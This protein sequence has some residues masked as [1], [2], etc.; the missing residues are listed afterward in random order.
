ML[1]TPFY[2]QTQTQ[3]PVYQHHHQQHHHQ[4]QREFLPKIP[5]P[6][7]PR[8]VNIHGGGAGPARQQYQ[9]VFM[10][11]DDVRKAQSSS[12]V[13]GSAQGQAASPS[14]PFSKRAIKRAPVVSQDALKERRREL[15]LRKVREGTR[16]RPNRGSKVE[17]I[18]ID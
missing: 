17:P 3:T 6:L 16:S 14:V 8:S 13:Q 5:S 9:P 7:S 15:F 18:A 1:A 12:Q 4:H 10:K 11:V 2:P